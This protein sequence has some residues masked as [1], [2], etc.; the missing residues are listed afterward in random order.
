[1][2]NILIAGFFILT[3][4]LLAQDKFIVEYRQSNE[5]DPEK[6][7]E[8]YQAMKEKGF[9]DFKMNRINFSYQLSYKEGI[10]EYNKIERVDNS[11]NSTTS[12]SINVGGEFKGLIGYLDK[13]EFKQE[14]KLDNKDLIVVTPFID[15]HWKITDIET[16]ILGYKVIKAVGISDGKQ[17]AAWYAPELKVDA[18]P[19]KVN[20]LPGLILKTSYELGN[21]L[22]TIITLE[23]EKINLNPKSFKKIRSSKGMEVSEAD[24]KKLQEISK[25]KMR[26]S[27]SIGVDKD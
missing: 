2:K 15:Y 11:N 25:E 20:G 12:F 21:K 18:G 13:K 7:K 1:M 9:G 26:Q 5:D 22:G 23:A 16:T 14:V 10:S 4:V 6:A 17:I 27:F 3:N 24:F 19:S 8:A